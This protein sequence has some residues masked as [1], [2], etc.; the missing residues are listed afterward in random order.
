ML[1]SRRG[2][3]IGVARGGGSGMK[4]GDEDDEAAVA[5]LPASLT[6]LMPRPACGRQGRSLVGVPSSWFCLCVCWEEK[7]AV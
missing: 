2:I 1:W 4:K 6:P 5:C 7:Y 3:G